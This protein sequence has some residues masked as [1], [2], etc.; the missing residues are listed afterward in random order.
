[1]DGEIAML[2]LINGNRPAGKVSVTMQMKPVIARA[3]KAPMGR[4]SDAADKVSEGVTGNSLESDLNTD[5]YKYCRR[6]PRIV[7]DLC[8]D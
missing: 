2:S 8:I 7:N 5:R 6:A 3:S 1:M 4:R